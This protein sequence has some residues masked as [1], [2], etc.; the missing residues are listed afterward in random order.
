MDELRREGERLMT[1]R[2]GKD[3]LIA[4]ATVEGGKPHVR[5]VNAYYE[6]GAFYIV[7]HGLSNKMRQIAENPAVAI[8]GEWFTGHGRGMN[9][10][11]WGKAETRKIAEKLRRAFF[12]W[13]D[14]G[15][16]DFEDENTCIL[17]IRLEDG[18]LFS[19]GTRYSLCFGSH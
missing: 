5:G 18:L 16:V 13:I 11:Y 19:H 12:S 10:G 8:S 9:L 17:C 6:D 7:T 4:L 2:F 1:E 14:N 3:T 15:H